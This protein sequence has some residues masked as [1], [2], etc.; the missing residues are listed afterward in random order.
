DA[1]ELARGLAPLV[2]D[3]DLVVAAASGDTTLDGLEAEALARARAGRPVVVTAPRRATGRFGAAGSL[4]VAAA[5]LATSHGLVPPTVG[6]SAATARGLD[7]VTGPARAMP[8]RSVL[9]DGLARGGVCRP[10]RLEAA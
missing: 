1:G 9:V 2:A 10:L 5:A 3:V 8:V 7:V 6:W 4:A